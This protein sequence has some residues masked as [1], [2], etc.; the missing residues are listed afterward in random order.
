MT[1]L[2]IHA[3]ATPANSPSPWQAARLLRL[4]QAAGLHRSPQRPLPL[5]SLL[6]TLAC[7]SCAALT[8][9]ASGPD[10]VRP[11][12]PTPA[13]FREAPPAGWKEAQARDRLPKGRWWTVF[14]DPLLD[15]LADRAMAANHTVEISEAAVRQARAQL[16]QTRSTRYPTVTGGLNASLSKGSVSAVASSPGGLDGA[17]STASSESYRAVLDASWETDLWG[18]DSRSVEAGKHNWRRPKRTWKTR[19]CRLRRT[20]TQLFRSAY[21]G[22]AAPTAG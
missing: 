22:C 1:H 16:Q 13:A 6:R 20:R 21:P 8:A 7:L 9:C 14:G 4:R 19:G 11:P 5:R 12:M 10:Y 2:R 17:S 3:A 18:T 15:A